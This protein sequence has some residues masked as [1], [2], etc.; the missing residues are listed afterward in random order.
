MSD[1]KKSG[2]N[3]DGSFTICAEAMPLFRKMM[4]IRGMQ[5]IVWPGKH[6]DAIEELAAAILEHQD[7][8]FAQ[9]T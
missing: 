7:V 8:E 5:G 4:A 1:E 2:V 6:N 3:P 9:Y